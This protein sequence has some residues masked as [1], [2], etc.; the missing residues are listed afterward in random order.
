MARGG[1][2]KRTK[3]KLNNEEK[4]SKLIKRAFYVFLDIITLISFSLSL[5]FT[6]A[7]DYTKTILFLVI[8]TLL[9]LFFITKKA[10][11][12]ILK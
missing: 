4:K 11:K 9:L 3:V 8:G 1:K 10:F 6:C 7:E 5:Y 12:K 2:N